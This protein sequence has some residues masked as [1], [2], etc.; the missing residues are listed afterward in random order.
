[1]ILK[2]RIAVVTGAGSGIGRAGAMIMG[3]E[4]AVVVIADRDGAAGETTAADIRAAGGRAEAIA[5]DVSNDNAIDQL[6]VGTLDRH[7][8]ID[9]L[10][11]HA[12]IQ[13]GGTL[14]E[15]ETAG[16]D[17]SWRVNV[18][19]Q[20]LAARIVMPS[21]I[22][23]GGGVIL[24][25]A[26]NSGVFYDREMIAYAT[27]KHAVVAMTRQMSLDYARHN[28]R[29][30]ALCPGWVDTPFNEPFIAQMGGRE[31]IETYVRTKIPMGRWAVV[32]EIAEAILFLVSDRSSFMTGQALVIDGGESI[33]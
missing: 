1:M 23:Q 32:E 7:Q 31:A 29:V 30:N 17:A 13:V 27:S 2:D 22:A 6:I 4:G 15:V 14:T 24:N 8:R 5:T 18:R 28:V 20:F 12:G 33:G 26:S 25:T 16:M 9:I 19:A 21:M 11:N 3:R 10:H